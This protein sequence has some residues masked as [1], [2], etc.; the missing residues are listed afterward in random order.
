MKVVR[1]C[2]RASRPP[3]S[4]GARRRARTRPSRTL[5]QAP[6][7]RRRSR[8]RSTA[9]RSCRTAS[10]SQRT[11]PDFQD[12][13]GAPTRITSATIVPAT[14]TQPEYCDVRGYVQSQIKFQLKLPTTTWQGRYLQFG[15][16]GFCGTISPTTFPAC[17][18]ELGRR[19]R[20]RRDQRRPRRGRHRRAVGGP[21]RAAADRLR[22]S[23]RA[24]RR[25]GGEGD[26]GGLLRARADQVLLPGLLRRRPRRADGGAA[27]SR[28]TSTASSSAHRRCTWSSHRCSS[29]RRSRPTRAQTATRSCTLDKLAPL[30][31]AVV[32]ACDAQRR[33]HRQ[34]P[35]RRPARLHVRPGSIRCPGADGPTCLTHRAGLRRAHDLRRRPRPLGPPARPAD[36]PAR[37]R[38]HV[39]RLVGPAPPPGDRAGG[40]PADRRPRSPSARARRAGS[41]TRSA[42]ASRS[43]A[44][45][46]RC[47]TSPQMAQ[48][49]STTT[50]STRTSRR[51]GAAA[52]SC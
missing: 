17:R 36:D 22:L 46:C 47:A 44:S 27:L 33:R 11:V 6:P 26:P 8:R 14:A 12:I 1:C 15:C 51:S 40:D 16:G 25:G 18:T 38:A 45:S 37:L 50:R 29:P 24:R 5:K 23:R 4:A 32:K 52:A 31:A 3:S 34:R 13:P 9:A 41:A 10:R 35:D 39:G 49:A 28:T 19:L 2:W 30:H 42:R 21:D 7:P 43:A 20:D 48:Q